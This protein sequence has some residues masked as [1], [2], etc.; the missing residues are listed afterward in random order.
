MHSFRD[1][2]LS[3]RPSIDDV[4]ENEPTRPSLPPT[5]SSSSS[6][7]GHGTPDSGNGT[8]RDESRSRGRKHARFSFASVIDAVRVDRTR[9]RSTSPRRASRD[10][11]VSRSRE[12]GADRS[13]EPSA[14]RGRPVEPKAD[15]EPTA[16]P[17][18]KVSKFSLLGDLLKLNQD[19]KEAGDGWKE[20]KKGPSGT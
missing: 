9:S 7:T 10:R 13:R 5:A 3:R 17:A 4:P 12:P 6:N 8:P 2:S 11:T 1:T 15:K 14:A 16:P 18:A 19:D 20:F